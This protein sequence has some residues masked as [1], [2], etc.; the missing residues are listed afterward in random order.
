MLVLDHLAVAS[1]TLAEGVAYVEAALG[2]SLT[3]GGQHTEMGTHNRLLGLEDGLYL[4]VIAIDPAAP[5]PTH[6]RWFDLDHFSG[7][8]RLTNWI[9][10]TENLGAALTRAPAGSG[11]A[12]ALSRGDLSWQMAVPDDGKLPFGGAFPALIEWQGSAHPAARLPSSGCRLTRLTIRHPQARA[13]EATLGALPED[14]RVVI[15]DGEPG[16]EARFDTPSGER[17]LR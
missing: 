2:V 4:E 12:M 7:P 15:A 16:F 10:R 17:V 11:V 6:A 8:P 9:A 13:L 14:S 1:E 5:A 3:P